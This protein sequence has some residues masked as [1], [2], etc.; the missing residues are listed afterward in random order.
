MF[1]GALVIILRGCSASQ[2]LYLKQFICQDEIVLSHTVHTCSDILNEIFFYVN[3]I[4]S[5]GILYTLL[6]KV[7]ASFHS[8]A[9]G[10]ISHASHAALGL[11]S[12][13]ESFTYQKI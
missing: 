9:L 12:F 8:S 1:Y 5:L 13:Q 3:H 4:L 10:V 11:I 2:V 6:S 7:L